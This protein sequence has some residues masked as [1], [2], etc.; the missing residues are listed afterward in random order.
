LASFGG[1][2]SGVNQSTVNTVNIYQLKIDVMKFHSTNNWKD[3]RDIEKF[4]TGDRE[5][6]KKNQCACLLQRSMA[7]KN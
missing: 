1:D 6:L 2:S 7:L 4:K 3:K 5:D